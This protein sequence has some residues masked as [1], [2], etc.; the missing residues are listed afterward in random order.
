MNLL[1]V[2]QIYYV[3]GI[4]IEGIAEPI[5]ELPIIENEDN[6]QPLDIDNNFLF[7]TTPTNL[8]P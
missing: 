4:I 5:E 6:N 8:S 1:D 3:V 2:R 7:N